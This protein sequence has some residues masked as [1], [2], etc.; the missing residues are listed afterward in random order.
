MSIALFCTSVTDFNPF[1]TSVY[2]LQRDKILKKFW[3]RSKFFYLN[4]EYAL[5]IQ[6]LRI[7]N[8]QTP[9]WTYKRWIT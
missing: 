1:S 8:I 2:N 9:T 6:N 7:Y 4:N 5:E 3:N